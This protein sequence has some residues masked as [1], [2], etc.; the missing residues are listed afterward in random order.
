LRIGIAGYDEMKAR[1]VAVARGEQRIA[2]DAPKVWFTSTES[3]AKVLSGGNSDLARMIVENKTMKIQ[4]MNAL[5]QEM[6]AVAR[7]QLNPP[8]DASLPSIESDEALLRFLTRDDIC[9]ARSARR[10][11]NQ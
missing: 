6:R 8:A 5:E 10:S 4:S 11:R 7:E 3:I 2:P 1:I 9:V